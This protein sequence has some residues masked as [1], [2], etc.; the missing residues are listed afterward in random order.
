[1]TKTKKNPD[2]LIHIP[3]WQLFTRVRP[4]IRLVCPLICR[5]VEVLRGDQKAGEGLR[6]PRIALAPKDGSG[7]V[8]VYDSLCPAVYLKGCWV[9]L[10]G[11]WDD[12]G[13]RW[14]GLMNSLE[15]LGEGGNRQKYREKKKHFS[16]VV[17]SVITPYSPAAQNQFK[18]A[19]MGSGMRER[20]EWLAGEKRYV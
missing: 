1:M 13:E 12:L 8:M 17:L 2:C 19:R 7:P 6:A 11:N 20:K 10:K 16:V 9:D 15:A 4:Y 5:V 18:Y 14:E 3:F